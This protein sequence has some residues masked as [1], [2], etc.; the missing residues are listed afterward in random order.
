MNIGE[1]KRIIEVVPLEEPA[2][3]PDAPGEIPEQV[4]AKEGMAGLR[5]LVCMARAD[6]VLKADERYAI[7]DALA[8]AD[9]PKGI[10]VDSLL[11]EEH[12]PLVLL[13]R[14]CDEARHV[15]LAQHAVLGVLDEDNTIVRTLITSGLPAWITDNHP[16]PWPSIRLP[17]LEVINQ[18]VCR[19]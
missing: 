11:F 17:S 13:R 19:S 16:K 10:T 18:T 7:E 12:D 1:P 9:L 3:V 8:G 14:V 6:G 4:P 15:T 2:A 5:L